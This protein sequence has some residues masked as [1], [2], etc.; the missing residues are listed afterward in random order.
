[1][2]TELA[3]ALVGGC[4]AVIVALVQ[5]GHR[6]NSSEHQQNSQKLDLVV[7]AAARIEKR[8]D[9]HIDNHHGGR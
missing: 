6:R 1:M 7:D 4:F 2:S 9:H 8:L 5:V 3:V